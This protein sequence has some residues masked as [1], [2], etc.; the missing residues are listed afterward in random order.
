MTLKRKTY[1]F[2]H[3]MNCSGTILVQLLDIALIYR[4]P[5]CRF[6]LIR[7]NEI[8]FINIAIFTSYVRQCSVSV[9][10]IKKQKHV[11]TLLKQPQHHAKSSVHMD[12][13]T[14]KRFF[15]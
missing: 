14:K 9:T 3:D 10:T 4:R 11:L 5:F 8:A 15:H 13:N 12:L 7:S 2:S 1:D 6:I